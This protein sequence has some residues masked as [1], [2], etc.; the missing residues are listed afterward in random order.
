MLFPL[1]ILLMT[2]GGFIILLVC[3]LIASQSNHKFS[4]WLVT[5]IKVVSVAGSVVFAVCLYDYAFGKTVTKE[6]VPGWDN[7][8]SD[9]IR[10]TPTHRTITHMQEVYC[11]Q[12]TTVHYRFLRLLSTNTVERLQGVSCSKVRATIGR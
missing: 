1:D 10:A 7:V 9:I 3:L 5:E 8:V 2:I 12:I 11:D 6:Y 4:H